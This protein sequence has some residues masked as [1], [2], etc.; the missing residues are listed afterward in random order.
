[1]LTIN[2]TIEGRQ[3]LLSNLM[4]RNYL[5]GKYFTV[6]IAYEDSYDKD[7]S[8]EDPKTTCK[9]PEY[10]IQEQEVSEYLLENTFIQI[11]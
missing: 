7:G 6:E 11:V 4:F 2:T 1:M 8:L 9:V 10:T 3:R 5:F